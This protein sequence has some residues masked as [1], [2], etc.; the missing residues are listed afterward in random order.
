[1]KILTRMV[2]LV[3]LVATAISLSGPLRAYAQISK[4]QKGLFDKGIYYFNYDDDACEAAAA[5]NPVLIPGD[6]PKT[7]YLYLI[8]RGGYSSQVAAAFIGNFMA[9]SGAGM[10]PN[11]N[12]GS[13]GA[14]R[15]IAQWG[16]NGRWQTLLTWAA[17]NGNRDPRNLFT[18]LDFVIKEVKENINGVMDKLNA[19]SGEDDAALRARVVV[20]TDWYEQAGNKV[21]DKRF[22]YAKQILTQYGRQAPA[23]TP[24]PT[25]AATADGGCQ[26][27][28]NGTVATIVDGFA[29]PLQITKS[30]IKNNKGATWC[31]RVQT[32]CHHDYNAADIHAPTGT[33][34]VAAKP[35]TVINVVTSG[36]PN[37]VTIKGAT[38]DGFIYFYQHMGVGTTQVKTGQPVTAGQPI[39]KVGNTQDA[40]G[41]NPHLHFDMLPSPP[42]N[43][44][45]SCAGAACSG[46]PFVDVQP[47]LYKVFQSLPE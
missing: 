13:G 26:A 7:G 2:V 36:S 9:E 6:N 20:I 32:N 29:F 21:Y 47:I 27:N 8:G 45:I 10:D 40:F 37:N 42:Y 35:G 25:P 28:S 46:R 23:S 31:W 18:Q 5:N 12:E 19:I 1:M 11:V 14:G 43:N 39:G 15:G 44:R 38:G 16:F 41:T 24:A 3:M 22:N 4:D 33:V 34:I 30:G 17:A